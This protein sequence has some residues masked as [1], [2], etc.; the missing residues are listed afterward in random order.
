MKKL[1]YSLAILTQ[2]LVNGCIGTDY[3]N[4]NFEKL[5]LLNP[6]STLAIGQ[7]FDFEVKYTNPQ[8]N[9]ENTQITWSSS[10]EA[11]A[12]ID[13]NGIVTGLAMG[14]VTVFYVAG[15]LQESITF[16]VTEETVLDNSKMATLVGSSGYN[17]SGT[18]TLYMDTNNNIILELSSDF[19]TDFALG[20]FIYL[21]NSTEGQ[22][23]KSTGL[24]LGQVTTG[25]A[26]TFDVSS[27]D[28]SVGINTYSHVV[29][30]CKPAGITF[31]F[32][33]LK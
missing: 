19:K 12:I 16:F 30:L 2:F 31:G 24:D 17:A 32:G 14:Q 26:K 29:V 3:V 5:E 11:I 6:I 7:T 15:N 9:E 21:A 10:D 8:G 25:G 1:L 20:T 13:D 33:E 27:F 28:N 23:V 18:A 22:Q 4:A